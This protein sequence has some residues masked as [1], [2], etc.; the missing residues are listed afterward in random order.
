MPGFVRT[1]LLAAIAAATA[2]PCA[3]ATA[4]P[5][6]V[7]ASPVDADRLPPH[8]ARIGNVTVLPDITYATVPG[9]RPLLFD[10]Y[11]PAEKGLKPLVIF[12]HGG[13][14]T[15]GSKR[16]TGH[17]DDFPGLLASLAARGFAVAS[18][19]YRL[20]GEAKFPAA[21]HDLKAAIRFLRASAA[22]YGIDPNRVA[23]WG[24]SS[25]A[26]LAALAALTGDDPK[27]EPAGRNDPGQSDRVQALAGWYG[28]YDL[29]PM[30]R[31]AAAPAHQAGQEGAAATAEAAGP[32]DFFGCT[33][34][35]CPPGTIEQASPVT[36]IDRNDPPS[37]LIHG[38][39]DTTVSPEQSVAFNDRLK[40]AGVQSE[41]LLIDWAAHTW[42]GPDP[43]ETAAASRQAAAATFDWL[44]KQLLLKR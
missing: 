10:L 33:A 23:L 24:A 18:I 42:T 13:S 1:L 44:E 3:A 4:A 7:S 2:A 19:D 29:A 12:V 28:P 37:L 20:S 35:G 31:Q 26:H 8:P 17:Y 22:A 14:W 38:T 34:A 40:A 9:Y 6:P 41:L 5:I 43:A 32:L 11:L 21:L 39:A 16:V 15:V 30:F 25:G 36:Y 27:F